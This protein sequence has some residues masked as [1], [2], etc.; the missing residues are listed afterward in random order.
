MASIV[1]PSPENFPLLP[2][3]EGINKIED[4]TLD[5]FTLAPLK[6][7]IE[8]CAKNALD[9]FAVVSVDRKGVKAIFDGTQFDITA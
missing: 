7:L 8:S 5:V 9:F 4:T 6:E 3:F 2:P 1:N